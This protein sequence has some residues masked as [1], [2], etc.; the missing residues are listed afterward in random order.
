[1]QR[2]GQELSFDFNR[3]VE[4]QIITLILKHA[5]VN[6][7]KQRQTE[8]LEGFVRRTSLDAAD[9]QAENSLAGWIEIGHHP[10]LVDRKQS[11]GNR[12][13]DGFDVR[14]A[15]VQLDVGPA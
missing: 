1:M 7:L 6:S 10:V 12:V 5:I 4:R 8:F 11:G 15:P 14:T 9:G 3:T 13:D 2:D